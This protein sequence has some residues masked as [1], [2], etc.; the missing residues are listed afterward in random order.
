MNSIPK[1]ESSPAGPAYEGR[2]LVRPDDEVVDQGAGFDVGTLLSR[3]RVL[4]AIGVGA[5]ALAL[6]ACSS[7]SG[8]SGASS[9]SATTANGEI[10]QETN[11]PYPADGTNGLNVLEES[12]IVRSDIT[13]SL[14]GGTTDA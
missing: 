6:A 4:G 9:T 14:E 2:L 11:G 5:G 10:P 1:P 12:G 8:G 7:E 13:R 3:R